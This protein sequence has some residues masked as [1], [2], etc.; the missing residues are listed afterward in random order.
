M[1]RRDYYRIMFFVAGVENIVAGLPLWFLGLSGP[2]AFALFGMPAPPS[3]FFFHAAMW[4]IVVFG[5]GYLLVGRDIGKNH[6]IVVLGVLSKTVFGIDAVVV[7]ALAEAVPILLV[8]GIWDLLF[9]V[10]F[11]EF[12]LWTR[13]QPKA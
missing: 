7:V 5:I 9:A 3:L 13:K 11:A 8:F 10:L 6:G 2:E 4:F 1:E 12:L